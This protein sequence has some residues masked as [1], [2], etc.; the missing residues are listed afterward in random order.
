MVAVHRGVEH[1]HKTSLRDLAPHRIDGEEYDV[2][3]TD[4][5]IN[6]RRCVREGRTSIQH[7]ADL[8][9]FFMPDLRCLLR[10]D[11]L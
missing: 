11:L 7:P 9:I 10:V 2:A 3:A 6:N 5:Y 8:E 1:K 4:R